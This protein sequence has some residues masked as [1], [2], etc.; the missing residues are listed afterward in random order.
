MKSGCSVFIAHIADHNSTVGPVI[1]KNSILRAGGIYVCAAQCRPGCSTDRCFLHRTQ[2]FSRI[3]FVCLI[4]SPAVQCTGTKNI[5]IIFSG[6]IC[7]VCQ[8]CIHTIY[9]QTGFRQ[10]IFIATGTIYCCARL[11]TIFHHKKL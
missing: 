6:S 11:Y 5:H 9:D 3:I 1:V 2:L 4:G 10:F 7:V 8:C